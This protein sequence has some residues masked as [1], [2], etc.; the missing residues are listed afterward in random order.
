MQMKMKMQ[1]SSKH[2]FLETPRAQTFRYLKR[3]DDIQQWVNDNYRLL[4]ASIHIPTQ[5]LQPVLNKGSV[6]S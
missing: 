3:C 1:I 4:L 2:T 5:Y 6:S